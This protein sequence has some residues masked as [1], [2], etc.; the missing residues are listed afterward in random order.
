M[1]LVPAFG[2]DYT[3]RREVLADWNA[4]RD[5]IV[6]DLFSKWDGKPV[7]RRDIANTGEKQVQ[8][9][10][11]GLARIAVVLLDADITG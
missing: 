6:A 8:I 4:D 9:R 2:R 10:Y 11:K 7:N 1:T 5:F 3:S